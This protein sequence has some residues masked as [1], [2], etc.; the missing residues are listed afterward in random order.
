M[1]SLL[2]AQSKYNLQNI[3]RIKFMSISCE[4]AVRGMPQKSF[5]DKSTVLP[6]VAPQYFRNIMLIYALWMP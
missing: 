6:G 5:G 3:F 4:V 2:P 1:I